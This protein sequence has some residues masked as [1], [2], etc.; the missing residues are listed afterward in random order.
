MQHQ[1]QQQQQQQQQSPFRFQPTLAMPGPGADSRS[2]QHHQQQHHQQQQQHQHQ[3]QHQ[4]QQQHNLN[5]GN[6]QGECCLN[7]RKQNF[8]YDIRAYCLLR[9]ITIITITN[10]YKNPQAKPNFVNYWIKCTS[11]DENSVQCIVDYPDDYQNKF[12][13]HKF[14]LHLRFFSIPY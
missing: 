9:S 14:V 11:R 4:Q 2:Q 13:N 1:H 3:H 8:N 10:Y 6:F 7:P 12:K 5:I